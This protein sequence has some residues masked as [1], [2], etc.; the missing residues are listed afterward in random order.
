LYPR[1]PA[2]G[3]IAYAGTIPLALFTTL[4]NLR[5]FGCLSVLDLAIE[6]LLSISFSIELVNDQY[7]SIWFMRQNSL[8]LAGS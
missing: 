1:G 4:I 7:S 6:E 2:V 5:Y 3:L 8:F